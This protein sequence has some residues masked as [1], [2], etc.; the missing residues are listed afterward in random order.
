MRFPLDFPQAYT[1]FKGP[2]SWPSSGLQRPLSMVFLSLIFWGLHPLLCKCDCGFGGERP[3]P[4]ATKPSF[5]FS[6]DVPLH[7]HL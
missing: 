2:C 7:L 4:L 3:S 1:G 6:F 5:V